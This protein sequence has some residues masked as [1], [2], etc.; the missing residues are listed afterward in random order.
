MAIREVKNDV[1]E[2][3]KIPMSCDRAICD[4]NGRCIA[5]PFVSHQPFFYIICGASGSGKTNLL[6]NMFKKKP[7][8]KNTIKS[9]FK[10]FEH[11]LVV[12]PSLHTISN[13]VFE[14]LPDEYLFDELDEDV[15][16]MVE[17]VT[18]DPN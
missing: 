3:D 14:D 11:V 1:L 7:P 10:C 12:S 16:D 17:R 4:K 2:V 13:N 15:F 6:I 8:V 9:Y 5:E 18:E